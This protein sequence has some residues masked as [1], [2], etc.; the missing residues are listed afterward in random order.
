MERRGERKGRRGLGEYEWLRDCLALTYDRAGREREH[1]ADEGRG[2]YFGWLIKEEHKKGALREWARLRQRHYEDRLRDYFFRPQ[3]QAFSIECI[4][5]QYSAEEEGYFQ[6]LD[7]TYRFRAWLRPDTTLSQRFADLV[8]KEST[9][10]L[11]R[12]KLE[13]ALHEIAAEAKEQEEQEE[14]SKE[15]AARHRWLALTESEEEVGMHYMSGS[16]EE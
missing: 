16:S 1:F 9:R 4:E 14:E 8:W 12:K 3:S 10:G 13:N 11:F 2:R 5:L 15:K 6:V 7:Q